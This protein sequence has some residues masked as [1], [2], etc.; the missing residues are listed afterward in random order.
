MAK[1]P[2]TYIVDTC[3]FTTLHRVYPAEVFPS[4]WKKVEELIGENRLISVD[5]VFHEISKQEDDLAKWAKLRREIFAPLTEDIQDSA[6]EIVNRFKKLINFKKNKSGADPFVIGLA[7]IRNGIV[8]TEEKHS[9]GT[10]KQKIPDV[11][12]ELKIPYMNFLSVLKSEG[13]KF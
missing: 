5:E 2:N 12:D 10:D 8:V 6:K 11:C 9:G 13:M 3:S 1:L 4:V 7:K